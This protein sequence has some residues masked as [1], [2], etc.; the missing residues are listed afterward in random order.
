MEQVFIHH[1]PNALSKTA[2]K[3]IIHF[4]DS[5]PSL[6]LPGA[7]GPKGTIDKTKI[8]STE[9]NLNLSTN[10]DMGFL[11]EAAGN[12]MGEYRR[13]FPLID[14]HLDQWY[15]QPSCQL[16]KYEAGEAY[17]RIHCER[18]SGGGL[19]RLLGWMIHLNTV[20]KG[21]ETVFVYQKLKIKP[22]I[23]GAY[24]WPADWTHMHYGETAP[25]ETKYIIT[26]WYDYS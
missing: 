13:L 17:R 9:I 11:K 22:K 26:G 6:H 4:F 16:M 10:S 12:L 20:K 5:N 21:G 19:H 7:L 23:G 1:K 25:N 15:L 2:C 8:Q 14:T 3:K 18:G 24:I